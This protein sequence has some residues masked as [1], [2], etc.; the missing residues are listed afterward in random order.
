[1][2]FNISFTVDVCSVYIFNVSSNESSG[3]VVLHQANIK[4]INAEKENIQKFL[5]FIIFYKE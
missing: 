2:K 5:N 3:A 4:T 1:M